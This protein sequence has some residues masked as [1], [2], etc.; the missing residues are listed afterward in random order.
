MP[1]LEKS[2]AEHE[3]R[4]CAI[5]DLIRY[6]SSTERIIRKIV[7]CRLPTQYAEFD[8]HLYKSLTDEYLHLALCLGLPRDGKKLDEA[9]L[10]RVHSECLTGDI[11]GSL[12]C[13][14]G[15]Q[16][17]KA[18]TM[19]AEVRRGVVLYMR[20]EGRGIGLEDK[21]KAYALQQEKGLDTVEANR[22]LGLKDDLR[23]Y[24]TGAQILADLGLTKIRL[25]TNNPRKI[26][27]LEGHGL[28]IAERVPIET[29]PTQDNRDYLRT[30]KD[31]LGHILHDVS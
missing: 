7:S 23:D 8:L 3:V 5:S 13:D 31:K 9:V 27:G 10:V 18:M 4:I 14:C 19:I 22:D 12:R 30:K 1:D 29:V 6:R 28:T 26:V 20:Q 2:A 16:L 21:L 24:G 25:L 15:Q 17:Q 11:F